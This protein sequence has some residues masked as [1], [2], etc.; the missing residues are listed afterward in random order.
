M[1]GFFVELNMYKTKRLLCCIYNPQKMYKFS[2]LPESR[3]TQDVFSIKYSNI[4]STGDF[5]TET[6][7]CYFKNMI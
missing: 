3:K 7:E 2:F 1:E 6:S 4:L 5:N